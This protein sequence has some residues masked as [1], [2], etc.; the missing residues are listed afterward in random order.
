MVES[1]LYPCSLWPTPV[2]VEE[3]VGG[4]EQEPETF[5]PTLLQFCLCAVIYIIAPPRTESGAI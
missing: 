1:I 5:A 3:R 4:N 2:K